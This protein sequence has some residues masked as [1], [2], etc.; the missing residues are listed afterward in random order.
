MLFKLMKLC[1]IT[2]SRPTTPGLGGDDRPN[3]MDSW[4]KDS[5]LADTHDTHDEG[6]DGGFDG[7][8]K[9][10][11]DQQALD[12][13]GAYLGGDDMFDFRVNK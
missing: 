12:N 3:P 4:L 9:D 6:L 5:P 1:E 10:E 2:E 8:H 13:Y 7:A 11:W